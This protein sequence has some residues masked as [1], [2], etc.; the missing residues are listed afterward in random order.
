M[1][2]DYLKTHL[3]CLVP[4]LTE[5]A[6]VRPHDPIE[7]IAF[8]L[9]KHIENETLRLQKEEEAKQLQREKELEVLEQE[10]RAQRLEE[11]RR[12]AE[13]DAERQL[14]EKERREREAASAS[15]LPMVEEKDEPVVDPPTQEDPGDDPQPDAS[16]EVK[17]DDETKE[18]ETEGDSNEQ[19]GDK[20]EQDD[21]EDAPPDQDTSAGGEND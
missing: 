2:T 10:R 13:E 12:L 8:W 3:A 11:A 14:A 21:G 6:E 18:D 1:E 9:Q 7:Y 16:T 15:K 19:D 17:D 20:T 4:C 5:V